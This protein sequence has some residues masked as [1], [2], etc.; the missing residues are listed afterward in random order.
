MKST[1]IIQINV[2]GTNGETRHQKNIARAFNG[3]GQLVDDNGVPVSGSSE[4]LKNLPSGAGAPLPE[5]PTQKLLTAQA[6]GAAGL[7][8]IKAIQMAYAQQV[9]EYEKANQG[10][11]EKLQIAKSVLEYTKEVHGFREEDGNHF[12]MK[13]SDLEVFSATAKDGRTI[14]TVAGAAVFG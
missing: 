11:N 5:F 1:D 10:G 14:Y 6:K 13:L 3:A 8:E 7:D 9:S 12:V 2:V 4:V